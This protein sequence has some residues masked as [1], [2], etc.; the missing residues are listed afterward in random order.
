[1]EI[2]IHNAGKLPNPEKGCCKATAGPP[3]YYEMDVAVGLAL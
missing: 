3:P 1:M 2:P